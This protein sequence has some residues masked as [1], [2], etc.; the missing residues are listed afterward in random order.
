MAQVPSQEERQLLA[1]EREALKQDIVKNAFE[2]VGDVVQGEVELYNKDLK[3]LEN[4]NT[5]MA[6]KYA[7]MIQSG[8]HAKEALKDIQEKYQDLEP[9]FAQVEEINKNVEQLETV[10]QSLDDY[11][12]RLATALQASPGPA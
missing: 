6:S 3:L 12:K 11:T 9:Y 10:V 5:A 2:K 4:M 7:A 8:L 1:E